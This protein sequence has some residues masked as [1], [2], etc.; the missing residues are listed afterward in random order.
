MAAINQ[1]LLLGKGGSGSGGRNP[2][3]IVWNPTTTYPVG[4]IVTSG[5]NTYKAIQLNAGVTPVV[6]PY[7]IAGTIAPYDAG[8]TY[9]LGDEASYEDPVSHIVYVIYSTTPSNIDHS[10]TIPIV[11]PFW[12]GNPAGTARYRCDGILGGYGGSDPGAECSTPAAA[13]ALRCS[14]TTQYYDCAHK[15]PG[16]YTYFDWADNYVSGFLGY[17]MRHIADGTL[18]CVNP[19]FSNGY[20]QLG[21]ITQTHS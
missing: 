7:W 12:Y 21:N 2:L 13:Q 8:T 14:T 9:T 3:P 4:S 18:P 1:T 19:N 6:G 11:T 16:S 20:V 15:H 17:V 5:G 10:P